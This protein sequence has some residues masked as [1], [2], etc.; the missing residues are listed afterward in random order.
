[1]VISYDGWLAD[2]HDEL[3][4]TLDRL[5]PG[6]GARTTRNHHR[7]GRDAKSHRSP[8]D[9][10][11]QVFA[12]ADYRCRRKRRATES[13]VHARVALTQTPS[14]SYAGAVGTTAEMPPLL[15]ST[16]L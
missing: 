5:M 4:A 2:R 1:M 9:T 12:R 16:E 6:S 3:T 14:S 11:G 10:P 15:E 13:T 7:A 8:S